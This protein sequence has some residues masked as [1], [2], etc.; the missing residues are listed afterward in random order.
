MKDKKICIIGLGYVGLPIAIEFSKY[1]E[2]V[3]YDISHERINQ[4]TKYKDKNNQFKKK[5]LREIK[6]LKFTND[7]NDITNSNIY[8]IT[9]PTPINKKLK[10]DLTLLI[11]ATRLV[12]KYINKGDYIIFES[13]VYPGCVDNVCVP[14]L[15]KKNFLLNRDF[16]CGYSPERINPGDKKNTLVNIKKVVAGSNKIALEFIYKLYKKIIH[17]GVHKVSNLRTAEAAKIIENVQRD[18]NIALI[19]ELAL[20]FNKMKIDTEEVLKAAS[21]KWNFHRYKPGLVGGHCIGVDPYY[22]TEAAKQFQYNPK[23]ILAGRKLNNSMPGKVTDI[24][25]NFLKDKYNYKKIK[26]LKILILGFAFKENCPDIRN[27]KI[28]DLYYSLKK[29]F[30]TVSIFDPEVSS[31]EVNKE[32]GIKLEKNLKKNSIDVLILAVPHYSLI[33]IS[34]KIIASNKKIIFFDLK[35]AYKKNFSQIRL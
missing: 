1:Y 20:I 14:I 16:F 21:T 31:E 23:L 34:K 25:L 24:L 3:G 17:A 10:P 29:K 26:T 32:Y 15:K 12:S 5:E 27:S 18:L 19:N 9:V 7:E 35:S 2:V 6:K 28:S 22:L 11:N 13:T 33:K 30:N 8:I 4:L